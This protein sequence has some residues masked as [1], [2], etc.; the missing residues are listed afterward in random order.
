MKI[1][2]LSILSILALML[3]LPA[4]TLAQQEPQEPA[5]ETEVEATVETQE[6]GFEAQV[7]DEEG[8]TFRA[9]AEIEDPEGAAIDEFE[10]EERALP[11][12]AS[13]LPLLALLG[14]TGIG[15]ALGIRF[16][17]RK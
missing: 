15:S 10:E 11:A 3:S 6:R 9:E 17:R 12:T 4:M 5:T 1:K 16:A 14:L 13:P 8:E 7:T 2:T